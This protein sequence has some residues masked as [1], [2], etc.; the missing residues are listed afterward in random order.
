MGLIGLSLYSPKK[1]WSF[2]V[3]GSPVGSY[4]T[5]VLGYLLYHTI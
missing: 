3:V 4:P 5:L 2:S 1:V